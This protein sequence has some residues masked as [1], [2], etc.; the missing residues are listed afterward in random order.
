MELNINNF[1]GIEWSIIKA[2]K[3]KVKRQWDKIYIAVDLHDTISQSTYIK[4]E[5]TKKEFIPDAISTLRYLSCCKDIVL[6]LY[7]SSYKEYLTEYYRQFKDHNIY[8]HYLNENPECPS[9]DIGDFSK[10]FYF[11]VLIDDKS[12]FN[13]YTDWIKVYNLIKK[14]EDG[15]YEIL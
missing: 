14:I 9:T 4:M 3:I 2:Y 8:F 5:D 6:I 15:Y 12:G 11:N 10:K 1:S 13:P 7:T